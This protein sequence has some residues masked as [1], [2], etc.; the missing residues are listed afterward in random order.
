MNNVSKYLIAWWKKREG[1]FFRLSC[2]NLSI[3]H[4]IIIL[5][6][7]IYSFIYCF[8]FESFFSVVKAN[9]EEMEKALHLLL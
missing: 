3:K 2:I 9:I 1:N 8:I 7:S 4:F 5:D 6:S